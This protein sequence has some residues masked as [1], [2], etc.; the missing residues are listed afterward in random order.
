LINL[1]EGPGNGASALQTAGR[2]LVCLV[3]ALVVIG[4]LVALLIWVINQANRPDRPPAD[5]SWAPTVTAPPRSWRLHQQPPDQS[6]LVRPQPGEIW[7]ANIAFV[8]EP[9]SKVRPCLVVRTHE[10]TVEVFKITSQ[11]RSHRWDHMEIQ[12]T[13]WD[14]KADH[15]SYLD[16]SQFFRLDDGDFV[17]KAGRADDDDWM[18][19]RFQHATGWVYVS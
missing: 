17:R 14:R 1:A 5:A 2:G 15:N 11:D 6:W 19:V 18:T 4:A 12:T 16:M 10:N 8:D 7:W 3:L 9:G 13:G